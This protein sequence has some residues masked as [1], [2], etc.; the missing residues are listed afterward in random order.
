MMSQIIATQLMNRLRHHLLKKGLIEIRTIVVA[1]ISK[2]EVTLQMMQASIL[3]TKVEPKTR[4]KADMRTHT[5]TIVGWVPH[6]TPQRIRIKGMTVN[7]TTP[8]TRVIAFIVSL[9]QRNSVGTIKQRHITPEQRD[10]LLNTQRLIIKVAD[11]IK[12]KRGDN[13]NSPRLNLMKISI[14]LMMTTLRKIMVE[15][16]TLCI[17]CRPQA[18][19]IAF[20]TQIILKRQ[21]RMLRNQAH[22]MGEAIRIREPSDLRGVIRWTLSMKSMKMMKMTIK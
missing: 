13:T 22:R 17:A 11:K 2:A 3:T 15:P 7:L 8:N 19:E 5:P 1:D 16:L 10:Q 20:L 6:T 9:R 4:V 12:R 18:L 14:S 21:F